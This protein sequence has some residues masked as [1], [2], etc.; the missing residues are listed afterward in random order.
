MPHRSNQDISASW[1]SRR[2]PSPMNGTATT[3]TA[4]RPTRRA[5][6]RTCSKA[7]RSQPGSAS[8]F[9]ST[10]NVVRPSRTTRSPP[11]SPSRRPTFTRPGSQ[12]SRRD[13]ARRSMSSAERITCL[14]WHICSGGQ[15]TTFKQPL[16]K[17]PALR[18]SSR[19]R[20]SA[21]TSDA[22]VGAAQRCVAQ[23]ADRSRGEDRGQSDNQQQISIMGPHCTPGEANFN[24]KCRT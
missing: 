22:P 24:S 20:S 16:R 3:G 17:R 19:S 1:H 11:A 9:T 12:A 18:A 10:T 21:A 15:V 5:V 13:F 8:R 6:P 7:P 2:P 14:Y 4:F 23:S